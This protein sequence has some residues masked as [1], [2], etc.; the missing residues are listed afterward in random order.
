[1]SAVKRVGGLHGG[2]IDTLVWIANNKDGNGNIIK[3][4]SEMA[5]GAKSAASSVDSS[6]GIIKKALAGISGGA[7]G[8][9]S[10]L[11]VFGK[12]SLTLFAVATAVSLVVHV[13]DELTVSAA[14]AKEN[15]EKLKNEYS[16][17]ETE[18]S[19][20][21]SELD[22]TKK[23]IDELQSEGTL[24]FTEREELENLQNQN[25]ELERQK[26][27]LESIRDMKRSEI[28]AAFVQTMDKDVNDRWEYQ[29]WGSEGPQ[30]Y[31]DRD[32]IETA[33]NNYK[34]YTRQIEE[35]DKEYAN[36]LNNSSYLDRR[37]KLVERR[38]ER[39][40]YLMQKNTDFASAS[41]GISY[42]QE[43]KDE[44]ERSVNIWLDYINDFQD[45]LNIALGGDSAKSHAFTR[46]ITTSFNDVTSGLQE[47]G[48]QGKVT[49][50]M[51]QDAAYTA[52]N[53][54]AVRMTVTQPSG[55]FQS[56]IIQGYSSASRNMFSSCSERSCVR[57]HGCRRH[58]CCRLP[59]HFFSQ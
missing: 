12:V 54:L 3:F 20:V 1:M 48:K 37:S 8:A 44:T 16:E 29:G 45:K 34:W 40:S 21:N 47:L 39:L 57:W 33:L 32:G 18:L 23:R 52:Y 22:E 35:L 50:D 9:W 59:V 13:V 10:S 31:S 5:K 11:G 49:W 25:A 14:E 17:N 4:F 19:S 38:Q 46:V 6:A 58:F 56:N 28:K 24:T 43:P 55:S 27:L 2:G 30:F 36:D 26:S 15:L 42:I 53:A 51:L 41:E 7:K